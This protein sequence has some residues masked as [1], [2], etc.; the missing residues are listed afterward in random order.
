VLWEA[1]ATRWQEFPAGYRVLKDGD[2]GIARGTTAFFY[3]QMLEKHHNC[4]S[5][6]TRAGASKLGRLALAPSL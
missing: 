3:H 4:L 2:G 1:M 5:T 6:H